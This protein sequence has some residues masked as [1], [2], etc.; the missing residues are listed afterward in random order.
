MAGLL[1]NRGPVLNTGALTSYRGGPTP[2]SVQEA[3]VNAAEQNHNFYSDVPAGFVSGI[4]GT[5]GS[6]K[7]YVASALDAAGHHNAAKN[8]YQSAAEDAAV[9]Q[10]VAPEVA[11]LD[12]VHSLGDA[13]R[14]AAGKV[15]GGLSAIPFAIAGGLAGRA[16][17]G[18]A[19][20]AAL[21]AGASFQPSM[22]GAHVQALNNDPA[23]AGLSPQEKFARGSLVGTGEA[24]LMGL[25]PGAM[26]ERVFTRAPVATTLRGAALNTAGEALKHSAGMGVASA[27]ANA[28]DQAAMIQAGSQK[29]FDIGQVGEEGLGG[30]VGML[31]MAAPHA[32][33]AHVGDYLAAGGRAGADAAKRAGKFTADAAVAGA[34]AS[35]PLADRAMGAGS[36]AVDNLKRAF[37]PSADFYMQHPELAELSKPQSIPPEVANGADADVL[38]WGE[39]DNARRNALAR[40]QAER[41]LADANAS[42][43][44]KHAA[45]SVLES[46]DPYAWEK[47]SAGVHARQGTENVAAALGQAG[48]EMRGWMERMKDRS[49]EAFQTFKDNTG[50]LGGDGTKYNKMAAG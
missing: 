14:W 22:A 13:G 9:A 43:F 32:L 44:D 5:V 42:G 25:A 10:N 2:T 31:P 24:A 28:V 41:V 26:A 34:K 27:G 1:G 4:R 19:G 16:L 15:G 49:G 33:G 39:Q 12:Q 35:A 30:A 47:Y 7:A 36:D 29:P 20:G 45:K 6:T 8:M 21:G 40:T 50:L 38:A 23:T 11:S 48:A 18:G 3:E 37:S 46:A 17:L